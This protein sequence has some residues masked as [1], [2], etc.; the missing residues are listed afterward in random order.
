MKREPGYYWVKFDDEWMVSW[1]NHKS[2]EWSMHY[3]SLPFK[4]EE[5]QEINELRLIAP[6]E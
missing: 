3:T 6:D 5:F 2:N 4:E 1:Y